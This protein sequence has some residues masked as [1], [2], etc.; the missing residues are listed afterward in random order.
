MIEFYTGSW[1][2][3]FND[4]NIHIHILSSGIGFSAI[5]W[6][7]FYKQWNGNIFDIC[8]WLSMNEVLKCTKTNS[9]SFDNLL[10]PQ[11]DV[12]FWLLKFRSIKLLFGNLFEQCTRRW[13][14]FYWRQNWVLYFHRLLCTVTLNS[15]FAILKT[16]NCLDKLFEPI[17]F[18]LF[19]SIFWDNFLW[20]KL[21]DFP[22]K[23]AIFWREISI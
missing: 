22:V 14:A 4:L 11:E 17:V 21:G 7:M 12:I 16:W 10:Y 18:A 9:I 23:K 5:S 19:K 8:H 1:F 6:N 15:N 2:V 13:N 3:F 20:V